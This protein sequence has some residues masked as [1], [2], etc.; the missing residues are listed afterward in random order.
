MSIFYKLGCNFDKKLIEGIDK[1]NQ[2]YE[3][4]I[5]NEVYGSDKDHA[6]LTARPEFR[7]KEISM[8]NLKAYVKKCNK[9]NIEFSYALNSI[10][11]GDKR[12]ITEHGRFIH[13][14]IKFL[15]DIGVKRLIISNPIMA[16]IARGASKTINIE[17]STIAHID[18]ITQI[19]YWKE[20]YNIDKV[21][22]NLMKNRNMTFLY[23]E[24]K[25]CV[26]NNIKLDLIVNEFCGV[27]SDNY[28]THCIYR[29]SCY[30][31]HSTNQFKQDAE[32]L[33]GYPMNYCIS[34]RKIDPA[35]WLKLR[36]ILPQNVD[37]YWN[38]LHINNFKI[39]GRT[40]STEYLLKI[41][42]AYM[43]KEWKDN[44]LSLWKP[45]ETIRTEESELKFKQPF[46]IDSGKLND[47][48]MKWFNDWNH[49]CEKEVCGDTCTYCNKFYKEH[50]E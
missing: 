6:F 37:D 18:A 43:K 21:C 40:G 44:L 50:L 30:I 48:I 9:Y 1:L 33:E 17:V 2:K 35:C 39:T 32:L 36:W 46:Y 14:F 25:Y 10:F 5:I 31:F 24:N 29:D 13:R 16:D 34:S 19:K 49:E 47:F 15:E 22:G 38:I 28:A 42:N 3:D 12:Q 27:G 8:A 11:P 45:L 20:K 23:R 26:D 7:L 4:S 41:A